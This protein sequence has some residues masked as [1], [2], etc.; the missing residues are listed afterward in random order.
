[1]KIQRSIRWASRCGIA[2]VA[3]VVCTSAFAGQK[4]TTSKSHRAAAPASRKICY[5][6]ISG[7]NF[8]Q[9][10]D[11]LGAI[12]STAIPMSIIGEVP[13]ATR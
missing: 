8:A 5:V 10:C 13:T 2:A 4:S 3:F 11:R 12:P 1:M 9:P 7:S 6:Q